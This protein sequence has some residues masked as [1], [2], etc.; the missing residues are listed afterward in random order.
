MNRL[1][2]KLGEGFYVAE[3]AH[4]TDE[5]THELGKFEDILE[6]FKIDTTEQLEE[7]LTV[8]N[9]LKKA[10]KNIKGGAYIEFDNYCLMIKDNQGKVVDWYGLSEDNANLVYR[11][12]NNG[13]K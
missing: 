12:F 8:Y 11:V 4:N 13:E 6:K 1:T 2:E 9:I 5:V 7:I 3:H 10:N